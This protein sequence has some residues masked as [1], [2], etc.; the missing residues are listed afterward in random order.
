ME[1]AARFPSSNAMSVPTEHFFLIRIH[2]R[3]LIATVLIV[4][5]VCLVAG[6]ADDPN[7]LK[8]YMAT[9]QFCPDEKTPEALLNHTIHLVRCARRAHAA[10]RQ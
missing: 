2:E 7:E 10:N 4:L 9:D 6:C 8:T 3:C 5:S 1:K